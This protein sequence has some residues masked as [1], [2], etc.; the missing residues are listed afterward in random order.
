MRLTVSFARLVSAL[1]L[2]GIFLTPMV[3]QWHHGFEAQHEVK[4]E[5]VDHHFHQAKPKCWV[6]HMRL[7]PMQLQVPLVFQPWI[8]V[9][10]HEKSNFFASYQASFYQP[11]NPLRAPP[12]GLI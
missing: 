4:C 7:A 6:Y 9:A 2:L 10:T 1:L 3:V 11:Q 5:Q 12:S 8:P